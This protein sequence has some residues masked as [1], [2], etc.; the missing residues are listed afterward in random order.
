MRNSRGKIAR[1]SSAKRSFQASTPCLSTGRT[2]GGCKGYVIDH[3]TPLACGGA[4]SPENMQWQTSAKAKIKDR[5][6]R[7][8]RATHR[9]NN[10]THSLEKVMAIS[11]I[12]LGKS[13]RR[14][15]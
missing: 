8:S 10:I 5:S 9:I 11:G 13:A 15:T 2:T 12:Y 1:S 14:E 3:R 7:A 4:D 6:E